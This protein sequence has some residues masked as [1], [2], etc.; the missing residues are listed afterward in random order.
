[1]LSTWIEPRLVWVQQSAV[2]LLLQCKFY[3]SGH[4]HKIHTDKSSYIMKEEKG[5]SLVWLKYTQNILNYLSPSY[6][7]LLS[8]LILWRYSVSTNV[9]KKRLISKVSLQLGTGSSVTLT[10]L[11]IMDYHRFRIIRL[12]CDKLTKD[13]KLTD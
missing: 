3:L 5:W 9:L 7:V 1:V 11:S 8:L 2:I 4:V 12:H 13:R 6:K 10:L